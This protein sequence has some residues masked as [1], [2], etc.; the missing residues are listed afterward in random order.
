MDKRRAT[1]GRARKEGGSCNVDHAAPVERDDP[2][3]AHER[4]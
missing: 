1:D 2:A 4:P 3:V